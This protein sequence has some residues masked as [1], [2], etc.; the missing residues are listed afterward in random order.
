MSR[1]LALMPRFDC[2]GGSRS[3]SESG[4]RR[5]RGRTVRSSLPLKTIQFV[6]ANYKHGIYVRR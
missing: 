5:V 4:V 1:E 2:D 3:V 6:Y